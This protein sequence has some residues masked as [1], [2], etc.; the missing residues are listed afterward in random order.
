MSQFKT[1]A[2]IW[3]ALL[4]GKK[5]RP[6][7][8]S[9]FFLLKDGVLIDETGNQNSIS[10]GDWSQYDEWVF[11]KTKKILKPFLIKYESGGT[12]SVFYENEEQAKNNCIKYNMTFLGPAKGIPDQ[13][14]E[15]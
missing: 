12:G 13:E 7:Y 11:P 3:Q 4:S 1:Q 10:F 5:I 8:R 15:E 9:G 6:K 2:E 14:V